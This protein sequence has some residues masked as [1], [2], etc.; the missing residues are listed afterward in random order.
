[1]ATVQHYAAP[2]GGAPSAGGDAVPA[3]HAAPP[4]QG[5]DGELL[6]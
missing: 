3:P 5:A 6:N 2:T 1:V 4:A